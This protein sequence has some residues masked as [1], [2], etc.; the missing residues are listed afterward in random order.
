M[1]RG[2]PRRMSKEPLMTTR[3]RIRWTPRA[4]LLADLAGGLGILC[5]GAL[6][7]LIAA[8]WLL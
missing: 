1:A 5:L 3:T 2:T 6:F 7:G 4:L 8:G